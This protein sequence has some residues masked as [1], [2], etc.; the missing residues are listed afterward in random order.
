[1]NKVIRPI[2]FLPRHGVEEEIDG[3]VDEENIQEKNIQ[4][5]LKGSQMKE[6]QSGHVQI[7]GQIQEDKNS[8][9]DEEDFVIG[10]NIRGCSCPSIEL[11]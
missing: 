4:G 10:P 11:A 7:V 3:M 5:L 9:N 2:S 1:L 6:M 8:R